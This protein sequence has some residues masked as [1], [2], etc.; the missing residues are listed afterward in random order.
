MQRTRRGGL[1]GMGCL[2]GFDEP[3]DVT[4]VPSATSPPTGKSTESAV[5]CP[6]NA[7]KLSVNPGTTVGLACGVALRRASK[8]PVK[9]PILQF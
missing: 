4:T 3:Q 5:Q 2:G 1:Y 9:R 7:R 6:R 8:S